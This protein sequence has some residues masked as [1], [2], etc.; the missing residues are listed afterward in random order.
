MKSWKNITRIAVQMICCAPMMAYFPWAIFMGIG[1]IMMLVTF[2]TNGIESNKIIAYGTGWIGLFGLYSSILLPYRWIRGNRV[3]KIC[4]TL[5]LVS[6][7]VALAAIM[8]PP[9]GVTIPQLFKP[10]TLWLLG[11]PAVVGVW[12]L[13]KIHNP[14]QVAAGNDC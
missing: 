3:I 13:I 1:S 8:S 7:F 4:T 2:Q 14:Q 5:G 12:N 11:G 9:G 6:G 10:F